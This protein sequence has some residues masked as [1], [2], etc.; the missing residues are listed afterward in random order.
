MLS[1][2]ENALL[3]EV[4]PGTPMGDLLRQYWMPVLLS[5]GAGAGRAAQAGP[6]RRRKSR[7]L[8][9]RNGQPGLVSEYCPHRRPRSTSGAWKKAGMRCVYHGWKFGLD[10]Q[11]L[12]MPSEPPE[13]SFGSARCEQTAYPC[14]EQGGVIWAYMGPPRRRRCPSWSGRC[15]PR[16]SASSPA[17][18]G[19]QLAPGDGRRHRLEPHLVPPRADR[20]S[21]PRGRARTWT[22]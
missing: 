11:C 4:G 3:T 17:L 15:C 7:R 13:S 22:A 2:E 1:R 21:R 20:P 19:L 14:V 18:A 12:E 8:P 6:A 10:G 5:S 9:R 16:G